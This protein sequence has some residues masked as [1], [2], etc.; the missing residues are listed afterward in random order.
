[1]MLEMSNL[2]QVSG[3]GKK[4]AAPML[5]KYRANLKRLSQHMLT[6]NIR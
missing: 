2:Q 6:P 1:M 3:S 5:E 4:E